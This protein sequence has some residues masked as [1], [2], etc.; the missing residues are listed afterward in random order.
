MTP[1]TWVRLDRDDKKKVGK[2]RGYKEPA[3]I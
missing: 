3:R 2:F 1:Y